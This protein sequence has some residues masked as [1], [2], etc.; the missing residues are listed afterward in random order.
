[1]VLTWLQALGLP[2]D[3]N[4]LRALARLVDAL[5]AGQ[6]LR[7]SALMRALLS[8]TVVPARQGYKRVARAW[9]RPWLT[10]ALL[11]PLLVRAAL[12]LV[13]RE[14]EGPNRGLT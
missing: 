7:P 12:V 13:P 10:S 2:G 5:L 4:A 14:R 11:T 1:L 6:S 3:A 8:P 9:A